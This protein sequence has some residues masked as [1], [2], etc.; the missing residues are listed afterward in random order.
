MDPV[1]ILLQTPIFRD[2][3]VPDVAELLPHVRERSYARGQ[4][5]WIEGDPAQELVVVAEGQLKAHRVSRDGRE[6][7]LGVFTGA[8][9]TGEVG[10]FHPLGVR[11]LNLS[12]MTAARCL[13]LR[14]APLLGFL[15]RHPAAMQRMLEQLSITAMQAAY[16]FSG[17]AFDDINRRVAGLI[18]SLAREH[19]EPTPEGI[20]IRPRLSQ[21]ELAAY[22]AASRENVNRALSGLATRGVVSHRGGHF[23]VHDLAALEAAAR[24]GGDLE[25]RGL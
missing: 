5:V 8:A 7:I 25:L 22:V 16:A 2:L 23:H 12:A 4:I 1:G 15:S 17:V 20:R 24:A 9:V 11:W 13:V 14:R 19:G 6:V 21:G 3:S 10:L 18:V